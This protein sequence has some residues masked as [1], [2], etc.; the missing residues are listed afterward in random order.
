LIRE[1]RLIAGVNFLGELSDK[2]RRS[3]LLIKDK[4]AAGT[5]YED[6]EVLAKFA[7][8]RPDFFREDNDYSRFVQR[9]MVVPGEL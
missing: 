7:G 4:Q 3:V 1:G 6:A 5:T 2:L 9:A 8:L